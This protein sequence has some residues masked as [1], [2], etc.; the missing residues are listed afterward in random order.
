MTKILVTG[1]AGFIGS[2]TTDFL[3]SSGHEVVGVDNLRTGC[4]A[5]LKQAVASPRFDFQVMDITE[6]QEFARLVRSKRPA[7][8]IHLAGLVSVQDSRADPALNVRL[9]VGGTQAVI[10]AAWRAS[11]PRVVF[12]SSAAVYGDSDSFPLREDA[13]KQP[14]NPYGEAK[15]ASEERLAQAAKLHGFTAVSLRYFN[16][17]GSRQA[18]DSPYSGVVSKFVD[19]CRRNQAPIIFGDG[20]QTRDFIHVRDVA[21]ANAR[22]ALLPGLLS[23]NYNISSGRETSL[24]DLLELLRSL[25]PSMPLPEFS[26]A[27]SGDI[28]RS[29]GDPARWLAVSGLAPREILGSGLLELVQNSLTESLLL[30]LSLPSTP[31]EPLV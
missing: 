7:V 11:V 20:R 14:V 22:A 19:C 5:N 23:G 9:N 2:H 15:L 8:I 16:V 26:A 6:I 27:Q 12:A 21:R 18:P 24:L 29:A 10:D 3:L 30:S 25:Q 31:T 17:Y 28:R 1:A 4:R 13:P